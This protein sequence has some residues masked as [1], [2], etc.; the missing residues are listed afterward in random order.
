MVEPAAVFGS[1]IWAVTE[2]DVTRLDIWERKILRRI[3]EPVGEQGMWRISGFGGLE[4][5]GLSYPS[6]GVQT[7]PKPSDFSGRKNPQHAFLRKGSK[8]VCPMS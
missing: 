3:H 8:A 1:K 5:A 2:M 6:S 4:R 7:R